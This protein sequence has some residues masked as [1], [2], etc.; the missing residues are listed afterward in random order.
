MSD[1]LIVNVLKAIISKAA[2]NFARDYNFKL[3]P[4]I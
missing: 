1:E 3:C 2:V 4:F